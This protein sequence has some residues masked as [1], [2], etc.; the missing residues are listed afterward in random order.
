MNA[1]IRQKLYEAKKWNEYPVPIRRIGCS[2]VALANF[3]KKLY[4]NPSRFQTF[5]YR[6]CGATFS[7]PS[8]IPNF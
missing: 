5:L 2:E 8:I 7:K 4:F 3:G 6:A 1:R